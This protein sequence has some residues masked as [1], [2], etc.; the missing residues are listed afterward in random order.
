M[1][2]Q[3]GITLV[4]AVVVMSIMAI[5]AATAGLFFGSAVRDA[6][7]RGAAEQVQEALRTARQYAIATTAVY[8]VILLPTN[9][10]ITCTDGTPAG[11]VCAPNRP[12]DVNEPLVND[13]T[14]AATPS[15]IRFNNMGATTTGVGTV[16]L[17]Y[18]GGEQWQVVVNVSGRVRACSPTCS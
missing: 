15:E 11:N 8:R 9:V 3:R 4:E 13:A 17:T 5:V 14:L 2:D 10:Q 16:N 18:P 6:R 12:P 1:R 7:T